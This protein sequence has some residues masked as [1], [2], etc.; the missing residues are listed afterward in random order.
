MA[1]GNLTLMVLEKAKQKFGESKEPDAR[2]IGKS[3]ASKKVL[4]ALQG[5]D[6]DALGQALGEFFDIHSSGSLD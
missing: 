6:A 1:K 4:S 5:G 3:E 2:E